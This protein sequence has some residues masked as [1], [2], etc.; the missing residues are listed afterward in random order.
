MRADVMD[1]FILPRPLW[2]IGWLCTIAMA[3][4]VVIM[5][6]TW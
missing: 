3:V 5:F 6:A 1:R 4:A 2:A